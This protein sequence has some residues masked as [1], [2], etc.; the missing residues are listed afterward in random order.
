[1]EDS[2]ELLEDR[3]RRAAERLKGLESET[4]TL[5]GELARA[6]KRAADAEKRFEEA[7]G[8]EGPRTDASRRTDDLSREVK[9]LQHEREEIRVRLARLVE[10]LDGL[11]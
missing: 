1:V 8:T 6:Q 7:A 9:A 5:R 11:E 4:K 3:I 2:F 10:L